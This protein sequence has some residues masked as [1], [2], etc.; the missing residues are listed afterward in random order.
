[1]SATQAIN[2]PSPAELERRSRLV[3][4]V[5]TLL[6]AEFDLRY[7]EF[8]EDWSVKD[9]E[10]VAGMR[11]GEGD[12]YFIWFGRAGT[13]IRGRKKGKRTIPDSQLFAGLPGGLNDAHDEKAF[14]LGGDSFALWWPKG[15][16]SW[17]FAI[18]PDKGGASALLFAMDGRPETLAKWIARYHEKKIDKRA[19][20]ALYDGAPITADLIGALGSDFDFPT[21]FALARRLGLKI[22]TAPRAAR[23]EKPE[24]DGRKKKVVIEDEGAPLGDAEF[25]VVELDG[26]TMLVVGGKTQLRSKKK[27]LY[28]TVLNAIRKLIKSVT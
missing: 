12:H 16:K 22:G 19:L 9:G 11:D 21:A 7:F 15:A 8:Y 26:E 25:R 2:L 3:T 4:F 20:A 13:L 27:D 10:R 18:K 24:S 1:M 17:S 6:E 23:Q 28:L 5:D 14:Q